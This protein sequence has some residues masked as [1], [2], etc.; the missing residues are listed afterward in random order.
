MFKS[1]SYK[2]DGTYCQKNI[3]LRLQDATTGT[4]FAAA[5]LDL[6]MYFT[7]SVESQLLE[8]NLFEIEKEEDSSLRWLKSHWTDLVS[9]LGLGDPAAKLSVLVRKEDKQAM[10]GSL[11]QAT[12]RD[13]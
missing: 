5:R 12:P 4:T 9:S 2:T 1:D 7:S 6:S 11:E 3:L 8:L 13:P 10:M